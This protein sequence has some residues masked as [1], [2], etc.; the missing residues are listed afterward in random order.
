MNER[1]RLYIQKKNIANIPKKNISWWLVE[2]LGLSHELLSAS[3]AVLSSLEQTEVLEHIADTLKQIVD[4][5]T[6]D[7]RLV[8]GE[9]RQLVAI[10]ARDEDD[11]QE[12]FDFAIPMDEGIS[13]WVVCNNEAQLI[14][15]MAKDAR[16]VYIPGTEQNEMQAAC[17]LSRS[18]WETRSSAS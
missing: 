14:N 7:V 4:Y 16:A 17:I 9:R 12:I 18:R 8:D 2:Y 3:G 10:Y 5:D 15:D 11:E 1:S 6:M 13:G